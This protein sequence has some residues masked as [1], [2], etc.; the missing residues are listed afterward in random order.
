M[1]SLVQ[2]YLKTENTP[3]SFFGHVQAISLLQK[4]I[5]KTVPWPLFRMNGTRQ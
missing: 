4:L 1:G 3:W 5:Y 2:T